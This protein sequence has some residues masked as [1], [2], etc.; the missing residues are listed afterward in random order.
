[1]RTRVLPVLL[2]A[3]TLI[4]LPVVNAAAAVK[5][6]VVTYEANGEQF[7]VLT[8]GGHFMYRGTKGDAVVAFK[9]KK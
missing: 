3:T 6:R 2:L 4:A 8:A 9:L 1:M 5:S 7:V